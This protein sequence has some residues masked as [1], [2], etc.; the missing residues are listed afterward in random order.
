M[1]AFRFALFNNKKKTLSKN[2]VDNMSGERDRER[3]RESILHAQI[4]NTLTI[5]A[6]RAYHYFGILVECYS[7]IL[8][9]LC[10]H[11]HTHCAQ[12]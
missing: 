9:F 3:E 4:H 1:H 10:T 8:Y 12:V 2:V 5:N 6:T 7:C 11:T